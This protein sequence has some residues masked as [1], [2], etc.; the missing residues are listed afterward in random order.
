M[1]NGKPVVRDR[2]LLTL[3]LKQTLAK[4]QEYQAKVRASITPSGNSA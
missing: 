4:A 1:I 3:D 2:Q